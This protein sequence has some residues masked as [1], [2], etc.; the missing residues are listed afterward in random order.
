MISS[1]LFVLSGYNTRMRP[2]RI[3]RKYASEKGTHMKEF[4]QRS[5]IRWMIL[6]LQGALIGTGAILP[7]VS[8][9][10]LCVAFG[11]YEPMMELLAHPFQSFRKYYR[12]FI[13]ILI[14]GALG[15]VLLANA[16]KL[17]FE[18]SSAV[19]LMLFAG[20]IFGTTPDL[21]RRSADA[22]PDSGWTPFALSLAFSFLIFG[23]LGQH[24][25][26]SIAPNTGWYLFCGIIWGLSIVIPGLSS[27][28]LLIFLGLYQPMTDGIAAVDF[29]VLIPLFIGLMLTAF[30]TAR[31]INALFEKH[32]SV[33]SKIILGIMISSTLLIV[34]TSFDSGI[35]FAAS[36]ACFFL[37]FGV[38]RWMDRRNGSMDNETA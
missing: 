34:P 37:G 6:L 22:D 11:I 27:S 8:G 26:A 17:L 10:V 15:F 21:M 7:G 29:S 1:F 16:V 25:V 38:A 30:L 36:L 5:V 35:T 23:F 28:S 9:G 31:I 32:Y 33:I 4:T 12:M 18:T 19:A 24:A 20:L 13:P 2:Y 14:G 3:Q